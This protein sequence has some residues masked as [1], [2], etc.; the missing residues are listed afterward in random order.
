MLNS[1]S[2]LKKKDLD[3]LLINKKGQLLKIIRNEY[4]DIK[5]FEAPKTLNVDNAKIFKT[6]VI[7][8]SKTFKKS[9]DRNKAKRRFYSILEKY[10]KLKSEKELKNLNNSN[11]LNFIFY[12]KKESLELEFYLLEKEVYNELNKNNFF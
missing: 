9:V 3:F 7:I 10:L 12:P 11:N 2:K 6:S 1:K 4:F 8:S 5:I